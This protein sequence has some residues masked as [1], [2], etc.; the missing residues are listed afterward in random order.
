MNLETKINEVLS[1][2][3]KLI[4]KNREFDT[5][6]TYYEENSLKESLLN[7]LIQYKEEVFKQIKFKK[8][9]TKDI[10]NIKESDKCIIL[11]IHESY[12]VIEIDFSE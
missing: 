9:I 10:S 5:F 6:K 8:H 12:Y 11:P 3:S 4:Q 1:K 7:S 2:T